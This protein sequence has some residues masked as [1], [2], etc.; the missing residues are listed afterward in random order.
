MSVESRRVQTD[1]WTQWESQVVNG[2]YPLRRFLGGS[3]HSAVFLTE[4][5]AENLADAAIK[6]VPTDTLQAQAQLVQWGTAV[7]LT[8]RHLVRLF[9]VGRC[10][11]AGREFLFVVMEYADQTLAE[12]LPQRALSPDEA[13]DLLTPT[14]DALAFLHRNGLVHGH[15]KPSN[16]LVVN[17]KLKLASDTISTAIKPTTGAVRDAMYDPTDQ[18]DAVRSPAA[19]VWDLGILLVEALTQR[20]PIWP[21]ERAE[22]ALLP[23]KLPPPFLD[24]VRRCLSRPAANRPTAMELQAHYKPA[25]WVDLDAPLLVARSE[26]PP[27]D[28]EPEQSRYGRLLITALSAIAAAAVITLG[29]WV[30]YHQFQKR[31]HIRP[32]ASGDSQEYL[33]QQMTAEDTA[34]TG[35][36]DSSTQQ[37][38]RPKPNLHRTPL[39]PSPLRRHPTRRAQHSR[40][41]NFNAHCRNTPSL[42]PSPSHS[43]PHP[44]APLR[45]TNRPPR[46]R[47]TPTPSS[48]RK[49]PKSFPPSGRESTATFGSQYA[50]SSTRPATSSANSWRAPAPAPTSRASP[51]TPPA[52]GSSFQPTPTALE[53]GC[54]GSSSHATAPPRRPLAPDSAGVAA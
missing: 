37:V 17:D 12:L 48:T 34:T 6:F 32:F 9:D 54:Y 42:G 43:P 52:S 38:P 29:I 28:T 8:H 20:T 14:L 26:P 2:V 3:N 21:D 24:I 49:S 27:E 4:Y 45:Q 25:V 47:P 23:V 36:G 22:K 33:Q 19:D 44:R 10:R 35:G 39:P 53:C 51:P 7:T 41:G 16:F 5:R 1:A 50:C 15:L 13:R 30:S 46:R 40:A 11:F 18:K 31:P